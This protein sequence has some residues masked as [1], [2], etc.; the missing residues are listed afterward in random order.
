M[1]FNKYFVPEPNRV[2]EMFKRDGVRNFF[3]RKIDAMLG[4]I[5]S[6][7]IID[8]AYE[9]MTEGLADDAIFE[10]LLEEYGDHV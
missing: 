5:V 9:L 7:K 10:K 3:N 2:L 1:G 8:R 6:I 4:D